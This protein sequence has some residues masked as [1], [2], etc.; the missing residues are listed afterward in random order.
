MEWLDNLENCLKK[1]DVLQLKEILTAKKIYL[2]GAGSYG[3]VLSEALQNNGISIEGFI[4][5]YADRIESFHGIEVLPVD[6]LKN[7]DENKTV[8]IIA[9]NIKSVAA[10]IEA[11]ICA[12]RNDLT[13]IK[14]GFELGRILQRN[15][16]GQMLKEGKTFDLGRC[17]SCGSED[18]DCDICIEYLK[19]ISKPKLH[20]YGCK[21][22]DRIGYILGQYCT[23]RCRYC[24][25]G[26][27][28]IPEPVFSSAEM[29]LS[30]VQKFANGCYFLKYVELIGGEPFMHPEFKQILRGLLE[31]E[32]IGYVQIFTNATVVPDE[33]LIEIL[34]S[35]RIIVQVSDY[36]EFVDEAKK[37]NIDL[38]KEIIVKEGI[39][40]KFI[41]NS[42]WMDMNC[43]ED[44]YKSPEEVGECLGGCTL[45]NCHRLFQGVLYKCPHQYAGVQQKKLE[46]LPG[47]Y[48]D[49]HSFDNQ[50]LAKEL[51]ALKKIDYLDACRHCSIIEEP[52]IVPPGEQMEKRE[53]R[54]LK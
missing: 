6:I 9:S 24:F 18:H 19:R 21:Q 10:S 29:I 1:E 28:R 51:E 49:I 39:W 34:K 53:G 33:E 47:E 40:H 14:K 15:I 42:S 41:A 4:D 8:I 11:A 50:Q 22:Y 12:I 32:N 31:L 13:V 43:F 17:V 44:L 20:T 25:E 46:L 48:V 5:R 35:P 27:P 36:Y 16:C 37:R 23:L 3:K 30:D 45:S 26:V 52:L 2:Y 38:T 54:C 7:L